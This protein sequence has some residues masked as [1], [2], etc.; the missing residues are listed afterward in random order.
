MVST[1]HQG[2]CLSCLIQA[3]YQESHHTAVQP[4]RL[5]A[6]QEGK[7][8]CIELMWSDAFSRGGVDEQLFRSVYLNRF[9]QAARQENQ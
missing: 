5:G 8:P 4:V 1:G 2:A 7:K 6:E 3:A 9:I